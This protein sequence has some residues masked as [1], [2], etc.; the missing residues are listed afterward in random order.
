MWIGFGRCKLKCSEPG[1]GWAVIG[2]E[3]TEVS[4]ENLVAYGEL[5]AGGGLS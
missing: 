1:L 5:G 4:E 3:L 2:Q